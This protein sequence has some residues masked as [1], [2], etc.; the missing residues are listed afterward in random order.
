VDCSD[1]DDQS[2]QQENVG[3]KLQAARR[4]ARERYQLIAEALKAEAGI[5][6]H[7]THKLIAGLAWSDEAKIL[8]PQGVTRRQLYVLAHECAHVVLHTGPNAVW[9]PG[10]IKEHEAETYAHRAFERY[11]LAVPPQSARWARD[12][13]GEWIMKDQA[14]GIAI[15]PMATEFAAGKRSPLDPLP[16]VDGMPPRDF[17]NRLDRFIAKGSQ[18]M[19]EQEAARLEEEGLSVGSDNL[20]NACATC[21]FFE[22]KSTEGWHHGTCKAFAIGTNFARF[23]ENHC[24]NGR[25][26]RPHPG[27]LVKYS[28]AHHQRGGFWSRLGNAIIDRISGRYRHQQ[29]PEGQSRIKAI[30][31]RTKSD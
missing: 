20:P 8:A 2:D 19:I 13:V 16:A 3:A 7:Y 14:D 28:Y 6:R 22:A 23:D 30:E 12:Y 9:K 18:T 25:A 1:N 10:H 26:W 17:S 4:A 21:W 27:L 11:G 5:K 24:G 29:S 15:C 31:Y